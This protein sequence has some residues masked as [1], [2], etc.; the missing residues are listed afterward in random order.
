MYGISMLWVLMS[1]VPQKQELQWMPFQ[2][3]NIEPE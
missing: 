2:I 3:Y 1:F